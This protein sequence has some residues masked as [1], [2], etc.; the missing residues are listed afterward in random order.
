REVARGDALA[1]PGSLPPRTVLDC[2]LRLHDARHGERVQVHHGTRDATARLTMLA[3]DGLWQLR[4]ERELLARDG[5]HVVIRRLA[6]PDTLGG[7]TI[8]DTT[9]RRHGRRPEILDRLRRLRDGLPVEPAG[10]RNGV[11]EIPTREPRVS[12]PA[13]DPASLAL[14]ER[15]R[16]AGPQLLSEAQLADARQALRALRQRGIAVRV[17]GRLYG[18]ADVVATL[19]GQIVA[20][21]ERDGETTLAGVRDALGISRKSAQAFLEH[22][23]ATRVTRRLPDDR[24]VL[25]Q[26]ARVR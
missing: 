9:A 5:D 8:L 4:L 6:P 20:L 16:D 13:L 25:F 21:I 22:L 26:S 19:D 18:H 7:G 24:R 14:A 2:D 1:T 10:T 17:S 11:S 3:D 23:D 12:S 15:L